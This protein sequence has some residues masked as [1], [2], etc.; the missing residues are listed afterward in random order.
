MGQMDIDA[1]HVLVQIR[2]WQSHATMLRRDQDVEAKQRRLPGGGGKFN[3]I[4]R[5]IGT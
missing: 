3:Q 2:E 4:T 1:N 5:K